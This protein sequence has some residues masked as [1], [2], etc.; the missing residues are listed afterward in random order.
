MFYAWIWMQCLAYPSHNFEMLNDI[1][2]KIL[3]NGSVVVTNSRY[4]F[5]L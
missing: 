2:R 5:I 1:T 4:L 3:R